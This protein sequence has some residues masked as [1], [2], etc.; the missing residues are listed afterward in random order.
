MVG[1]NG[2]RPPMI[3]MHFPIVETVPHR[4]VTQRH[5]VTI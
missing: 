2:I 4:K 3:Q 5:Q 1:A